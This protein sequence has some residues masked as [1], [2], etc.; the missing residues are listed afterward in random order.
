MS[1]FEVDFLLDLLKIY[2]PTGQETELAKLLHLKM[3]ELGFEVRIDS[4]GNVIGE[5]KGDGPN[6]LLCGHMDTVPGFIPVK[7]EN[8]EIWGRGA[9]D[10]KGPLAALVLA[11]KR[12][13]SLE[14]RGL[15]IIV[16]GVVEEEGSSKGMYHLIDSIDEPDIAIFG[17]PSG[18]SCLTL[19]Y[20]GGVTFEVTVETEGGHSASPWLFRNSIEEAWSLWVE[21]KKT[22]D[23]YRKGD[24]KFYSLT[25]CLTFING[26]GSSALTPSRCTLKFNTR[27]PP[28]LKCK[29]AVKI[30][31]EVAKDFASNRSVKV[32]VKWDD[33]VE[34]YV[35]SRT[36]IVARAFSRAIVEELGVKPSFAYKTGTSDI[37]VAASKWTRT[38]MSAYGPGDSSLDHTPRERVSINEYL[39][40]INVLWRALMWIDKFKSKAFLPQGSL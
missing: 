3:K 5:L 8:E 7:I 22:F 4:V 13:A 17:E 15:N 1:S 38:E 9:V 19:G 36:S 18:A 29:D 2:S 6:V 20:K 35:L 12:Y 21:L 14:K 24:S 28:T 16:A 33:C 34:A 25:Y 30:V 10:A 27:I 31:R 40:A 32:E 39:K 23:L 11:A 26:G 37:N